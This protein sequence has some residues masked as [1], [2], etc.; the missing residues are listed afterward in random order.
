VDGEICA[1]RVEGA[2]WEEGLGLED[3]GVLAL[4]ELACEVNRVAVWVVEAAGWFLVDDGPVDGQAQGW[5][6]VPGQVAVTVLVEDGCRGEGVDA[7]T[8]G[9]VELESGLGAQAVSGRLGSDPC[10]VPGPVWA[11]VAVGEDGGP[12]VVS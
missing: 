6:A 8:G 3:D 1:L 11:V 12:L 10:A 2:A 9:G 4:A 5:G 7:A